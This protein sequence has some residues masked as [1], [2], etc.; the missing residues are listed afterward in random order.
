MRHYELRTFL[1]V[2]KD[3][4]GTPTLEANL[5]LM[6]DRASSIRSNP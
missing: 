2:R 4:L 1:K 5:L 6:I 3:L